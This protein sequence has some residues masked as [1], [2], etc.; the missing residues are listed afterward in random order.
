MSIRS[1]IV[2]PNITSGPFLD[3]Y[4]KDLVVTDTITL[5]GVPLIPIPTGPTGPTG[6]VGPSS[7][8]NF[9]FTTNDISTSTDNVVSI[10]SLNHLKIGGPAL[11][12]TDTYGRLNVNNSA[13]THSVAMGVF[14]TTPWV[15]ALQ[16]F[17]T[18]QDLNLGNPQ[19]PTVQ[20]CNLTIAGSKYK[21][22]TV[23]K[24]S[25]TQLNGSNDFPTSSGKLAIVGSESHLNYYSVSPTLAETTNLALAIGHINLF[26]SGGYDSSVTT[27]DFTPLISGVNVY[28]FKYI[29]VPSRYYNISISF[30]YAISAS[31]SL[32]P[33]TIYRNTLGT[34]IGESL[35]H[36]RTTEN[37]H[38]FS[39]IALLNTNDEI[40]FNTTRA[41]GVLSVYGANL[42]V[43]RAIN[44]NE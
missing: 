35:L 18:F 31:M 33:I 10:P 30:L 14:G 5:N 24:L 37:S 8:A 40:F 9:I 11:Q 38:C 15:A 3:V 20:S 22:A 27:A 41:A 25:A 29:G 16:N 32:D 26:N 28:G 34:I 21:I 13:F 7:T 44:N 19:V 12:E 6:P 39:T 2:N 42:Q 43:T 36:F 17:V 4:T 23:E 1:L